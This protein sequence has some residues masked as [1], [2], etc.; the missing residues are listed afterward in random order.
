METIIEGR[1]H[2]R[3]LGALGTKPIGRQK[4]SK[5]WWAHHREWIAQPAEWLHT[6]KK[7]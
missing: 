4:S 5:L 2:A 1:D 7:E 6:E 3:E